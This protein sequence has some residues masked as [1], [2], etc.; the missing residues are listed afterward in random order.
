MG[1]SECSMV[2]VNYG[3][4]LGQQKSD[5]NLPTYRLTN[6]HPKIEPGYSKKHCYVRFMLHITITI[7]IISEIMPPILPLSLRQP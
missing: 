2:K 1:L 7:P 4:I 5:T 6:R 3:A